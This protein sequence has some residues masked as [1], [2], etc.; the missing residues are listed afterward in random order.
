[1]ASQRHIAR[2]VAMQTI[3]SLL[4]RPGLSADDAFLFVLSEFPNNLQDPEFAK[5]LVKEA[6][7]HRTEIEEQLF[8]HSYDK[9]NEKIDPITLAILLVGAYELCYDEQKQAPAIIIN[10]AVELAK[11]YGKETSSSLV[12]ALL[13]KIKESM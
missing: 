3:F 11:E 8:A 1:M 6:L 9:H 5:R 4:H 2:I 10:E 7:A 13:S 12:N